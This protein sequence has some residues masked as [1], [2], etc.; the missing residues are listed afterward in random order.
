MDTTTTLSALRV[1]SS[2]PPALP[3]VQMPDGSLALTAHVARC[4]VLLYRDDSYPGGVRRELVTPEELF[5]ADSLATLG[6]ATLTLEHPPVMLTPATQAQYSAGHV[7]STVDV[8]PAEGPTDFGYVRVRAFLK[9]TPAIE[10]MQ[11]G[12]A[13]EFSPGYVCTL[14]MT[15]GTHPVWGPYDAIQRDRKYNH[16]AQTSAARGGHQLRALQM[17]SAGRFDSVGVQITTQEALMPPVQ[18][19]LDSG[20]SVEFADP[21]S[22]EVMV[23]HLAKV[24]KD[25]EEMMGEAEGE[26]TSKKGLI[27]KL[28]EELAAKKKLLEEL[29][30]A[31]EV[32]KADAAKERARA[33]ALEKTLADPVALEAI[34]KPR[35]DA[36]S[37]A[38]SFGVAGADKWDSKITLADMQR[39]TIKHLLPTIGERVDSMTPD[40]L[41]GAYVTA[42]ATAQSSGGAARPT[43]RA[44]DNAGQRKDGA[45]ASLAEI[46][47]K[48]RNDAFVAPKA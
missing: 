17:D 34:L 14:D 16:L 41:T 40:A 21:R 45:G 9:T 11:R 43:Y 26:I 2:V 13:R 8:V 1:D 15:P 3:P 4:G 47:W 27:A 22:Q 44:P 32:V 7:D 33:D 24:R 18:L 25:Q 19:R 20:V 30:G 39:A 6:A 42:M 31:A 46:Q 29:T 36:L 37:A 5:K 23:A 28:E 38:K 12:D 35:L 48:Q 10:A